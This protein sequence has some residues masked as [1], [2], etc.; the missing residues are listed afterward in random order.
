MPNKRKNKRK[1]KQTIERFDLD[2][3][4]PDNFAALLL[5]LLLRRRKTGAPLHVV[6]VGRRFSSQFSHAVFDPVSK[7]FAMEILDDAPR[8]ECAANLSGFVM[9]APW[10]ETLW[11]REEE[12]L[13]IGL[14]AAQLRAFLNQAGVEP[15]EYELYHGGF[16]ALAGLSSHLHAYDFEFL[17]DADCSSYALNSGKELATF[18]EEWRRMA[19][20]ERAHHFRTRA[21]APPEEMRR[22][23]PLSAF[24]E[25]CSMQPAE[26]VLYVA[27][28]MTA[29]AATFC[30]D[31][32]LAARVVRVQAM[33]GAWDG[34]KNLLGTC[35]N[36]AV[37]M[38]ATIAA[39]GAF[40]RGVILLVPTETCKMGPFTLSAQEIEAMPADPDLIQ[41]RDVLAASIQQW[42]ELK[43]APQPLFDAVILFSMKELIEHAAVVPARVTFGKNIHAIGTRFEDLGMTLKNATAP[44]VPSSVGEVP[45]ALTGASFPPGIYATERVFGPGCAQA[46]KGMIEAALNPPA[47]PAAKRR[48]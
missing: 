1:N 3:P 43:R 4:D 20:G 45:G 40:P 5:K 27:S 29:V 46:F 13:L 31:P 22:L 21:L 10:E 41:A 19:P 11:N 39:L 28:P 35:F 48:K 34:S 2:R 9:Q 16:P 14:Y 47:K 6:L 23:L 38:G 25:A 32:G 26:I 15:W 36:N 30:G 24:S 18:A 7:T 37:D 8:I 12:E 42:T 44:G 33:G 17:K